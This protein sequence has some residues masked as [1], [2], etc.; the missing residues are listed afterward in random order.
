MVEV[1]GKFGGWVLGVMIFKIYNYKDVGFNIYE[2]LF[3]FC[4]VFIL[5][6]CFGVWGFKI[7]YF[8]EIV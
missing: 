4:V 1:L 5:D 6:Y 2:K 7:Y 3:Y 8:I